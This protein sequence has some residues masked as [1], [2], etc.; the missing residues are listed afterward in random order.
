MVNVYAVNPQ[1]ELV[2]A[3]ALEA[4]LEEVKDDERLSRLGLKITVSSQ[5][6]SD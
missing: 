1:N 4:Y 3:A 5:Q 2:S 6:L